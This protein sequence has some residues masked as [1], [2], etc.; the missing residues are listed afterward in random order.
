VTPL[1]DIQGTVTATFLERKLET[2]H[3]LLPFPL[4]S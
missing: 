3:D 4:Y 1:S 2:G